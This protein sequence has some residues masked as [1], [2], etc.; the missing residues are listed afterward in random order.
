MNFN[1]KTRVILWFTHSQ[2]ELL[3]DQNSWSKTV[4]KRKEHKSSQQVVFIP[5]NVLPASGNLPMGICLCPKYYLL[6]LRMSLFS[7]WVGSFLFWCHG[8]FLASTDAVASLSGVLFFFLSSFL[9]SF[10][11]LSFWI[12]ITFHLPASM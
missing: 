3:A 2:K 1:T 8:N 6:W 7:F 9:C 10:I 11:A 4:S 5:P 12:L